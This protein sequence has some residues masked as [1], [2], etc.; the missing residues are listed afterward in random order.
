MILS[1]PKV[2]V[3]AEAGAN[4]NN[5]FQQAL[6]MIDIAK[7]SGADACKFQTYSAETLFCKNTPNFAN[8]NNINDLIK[9]IEIDRAWQKDLKQYCDER[10]IEFMSTPF[11][12]K[13]VQEL[14]DLDVKRIKIA[15]FESTDPRFVTMVAQTKKPL[16]VSAGI[17]SN[18]DSIHKIIEICNRYGCGDVTI[19]H[20]NN[21]YPT[22]Q[23]DI[24]LNTMSHIKQKFNIAV[25][26]SDHTESP[27]TPALAVAMGAVMIEKHF[28]LSKALP[29]P[30]H[31]FAVTPDQLVQMVHHIRMAEKSLRIRDGL[32]Q[33]E[34]D[35]TMACRSVVSQKNIT[36]GTILDETY[37]TT[38]R[39]FTDG[40]IAAK[41]YYDI[42]G[43]EAKEDINADYPILWSQILSQ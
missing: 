3:I 15:G 37:I 24:N 40:A 10:Q 41:H 22:P 25:G 32:S 28:T 27:F 31:P 34:Q 43:K 42:L 1:P 36:K 9:S 17:G 29:G 18:D 33:S 21:A 12:E 14:V 26:L 11:D 2:F 8:Y 13:A 4:H 7:K 19:L 38:K 5:N 35:F 16:I 30:D 6:N 23:E 20:C 39:P